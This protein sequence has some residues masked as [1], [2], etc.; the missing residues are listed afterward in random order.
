MRD[1]RLIILILLIAC[2][3]PTAVQQ[4]SDSYYEDLSIHR[5]QVEA[6]P[7]DSIASEVT[8]QEENVVISGHIKTEMDSVNRIMIAANQEKKWDGFR[9]QIYVGN[10][11][12]QA[13]SMLNSARELFPGYESS[14]YYYQPT[15]RVKVGYFFDK[16]VAAKVYDEMKKVYT[17]AMLLPEKL[18][19]P[20]TDE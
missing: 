18:D 2:K 8:V 7:S 19:L 3:A 9:I 11:R 10:S 6:E 14:M 5:E 17:K 13:Q 16:L 20:K 15:Y 4:A 12:Q 1:Y